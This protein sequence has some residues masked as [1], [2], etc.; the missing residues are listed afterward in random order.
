MFRGIFVPLVTPFVN[1]NIDWASF[2]NLIEYYI[3]KGVDGLVPCGTTGESP[4]LSE[5]E[6]KDVVSFTV[7]KTAGRVMVIAGTGSN[8]TAKAVEFT[9]EAEAVGANG[10]LIVCPYYNK[11]TQEGIIAHY[12]EIIRKSSLPVVVYNIPGRTGR[13]IEVTTLMSL[14]SLPN[15]VGVK[16]A[17]G[18]IDQ[19]MDT[20]AKRPE[21]FRVLSGED[22]LIYL[23]CALGGDGAIAASAHILPERFK[24]MC[25]AT[26]KGDASRGAEIHF[27]L[28]PLIRLLFAETN[29]SPIKSALKMMGLISSED[30][31]LPL[32]PASE[33]LKAKIRTTLQNLGVI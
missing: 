30:V 4:T 19:L 13:N 17:S 27:E 31:R 7:R 28:L 33:T 10:A 29:P 26:W 21:G 20:I 16:E 23:N 15:I 32:V 5:K 14:A 12:T 18:N 24:E 8:E 11:P 3:K 1:G 9:R 6:H 25:E 2:E 22:H